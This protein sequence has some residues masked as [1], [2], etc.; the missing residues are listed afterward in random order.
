MG[1]DKST[2]QRLRLIK[3]VNECNLIELYDDI[4]RDIWIDDTIPIQ[5]DYFNTDDDILE[6]LGAHLK[7]TKS[8]DKRKASY[9]LN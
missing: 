2:T 3:F 4:D 1:S 6:Y 9:I 7:L 8:S 5:F